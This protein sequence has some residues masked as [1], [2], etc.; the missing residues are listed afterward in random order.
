M[1]D[2]VPIPSSGVKRFFSHPAYTPED[3]NG[4]LVTG[5]NPGDMQEFDDVSGAHME[6]DGGSGFTTAFKDTH[7]QRS[8]GVQR[9]SMRFRDSAPRTITFTTPK[10]F[11]R[12]LQKFFEVV[13]NDPDQRDAMLVETFTEN[14]VNSHRNVT[15]FGVS[16]GLVMYPRGEN[17]MGSVEITPTAPTVKERP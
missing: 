17:V 2:V 5:A 15:K 16:S 6:I 12:W 14:D 3:S 11:N 13:E 1:P 8:S 10:G 7:S 9:T 4:V